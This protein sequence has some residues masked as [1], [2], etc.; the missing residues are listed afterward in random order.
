MR[1]TLGPRE[2]TLAAR[3]YLNRSLRQLRSLSYLRVWRIFAV[4]GRTSEARNYFVGV[5]SV[6][7][8]L[9]YL[10]RT[11]HGYDSTIRARTY[12]GCKSAKIA[13][14]DRGQTTSLYKKHFGVLFF[15]HRIYESTTLGLLR[16]ENKRVLHMPP[17]PKQ[18]PLF[19]ERNRPGKR[20]HV[21]ISSPLVRDLQCVVFFETSNL[22]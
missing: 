19:G 21:S 13:R 3:K 22:F 10:S 5:A 11:C 1:G 18:R 17:S 2:V 20:E 9:Q 12:E 8:G 14:H 16:H 7:R 6:P 4:R 15:H